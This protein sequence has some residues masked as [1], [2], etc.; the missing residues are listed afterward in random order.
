MKKSFWITFIVIC[1]VNLILWNVLDPI[2][3]SEIAVISSVSFFNRIVAVIT[4]LI[5][6]LVIAFKVNELSEIKA[7]ADDCKSSGVGGNKKGRLI[8]QIVIA[9]VLAVLILTTCRF[10]YQKIDEKGY[11][12]V[13]PVNQ[14][15]Y[16]WE[17]MEYYADY[18]T[19]FAHMSHFKFSRAEAVERFMIDDDYALNLKLFR[20]NRLTDAAEQEY[21]TEEDLLEDIF[22][23]KYG[24]KEAEWDHK[25]KQYVPKDMITE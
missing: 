24:D 12:F 25:E 9:S 17:D 20:F 10:S 6:A 21:K 1:V 15:T 2:D 13:S 11:T 19:E 5:E 14:Y 23:D 8:K 7:E 3:Q 16:L 4:A 18:S 22:V